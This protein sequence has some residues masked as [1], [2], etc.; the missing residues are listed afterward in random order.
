MTIP[1]AVE[2]Q[3]DFSAGELDPDAE[4][5]D[6][7]DI[8]KAGLKKALNTRPLDVKGITRRQGRRIRYYETGLNER[9]S[10]VS[11]IEFDVTLK[12]NRF[13][14]RDLTGA[15]VSDLAA[16]WT[17][18]MLPELDWELNEKE[19]YVTHRSMPTQVITYDSDAGTWSIADFSF[20]IGLSGETRIPFYR[21]ADFGVTMTPS[22]L[23]GS[24][25][26][27][28]SA[29]VLESQH[30]G[31]LFRYAERQIQIDSITDSQNAAATVIEELPRTQRLTV[32]DIEGYSVGE[33]VEGDT[34]NTVGEIVAVA[35]T[36]VDVVI[37]K[38]LGGFKTSDTLIGPNARSTVSNVADITPGASVQWD[39][40][41]ISEFRG[42]PGAV[43]K[44]RKRLVLCDF[45]QFPEAVLWS[46]IDAPT[47]FKTTGTADGSIF[48]YVPDTGRVYAVVGGADQFVFT[49]R[50][51]YYI[52]ISGSTPLAPG[53]VEFRRIASEGA[54]R[55]RPVAVSD[56]AVFVS[57]KKTRIMAVSATGQ[58]TRPYIVQPISR[59]HGHL[60]KDPIAI[61]AAS[62]AG[63]VPGEALYCVNADG[64][65]IVAR[66]DEGDEWV[67][68]FPWDGA[69]RITDVR[70]G[71]DQ[72]LM[73]V[74][75]DLGMTI[76]AV[77][78]PD[79]D[80]V[81]DSPK[82]A[83]EGF[84][85][86]LIDQNASGMTLVPEN[87][88][89]QAFFVPK[90]CNQCTTPACVQVC[91]VGAT[92][93][94]ADGVVL[95]D[96]TWCIGCGYCIMGCPYG[97]RFF[98]PVEHVADKCTFCYHRII[99]GDNSACAQA[100]PFNAR[101]IGNLKDPNDPVAKAVMT[102]RVGVLRDEYGT[103]PNVYYIGLNKEVR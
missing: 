73:T 13:V 76:E 36:T 64:T 39:E 88:I 55:V 90:L 66:Y 44:D 46:A 75:Y 18:G 22:A 24:I 92:Y 17:L 48:E 83:R 4:R 80:V 16:P 50:R 41:F 33:V 32:P 27:T 68:W 19:I 25:T 14:A 95:V 9:V 60:V 6:D 51:V 97:V 54:A 56:G 91:P 94:T 101:Q 63:G 99:K 78:E 26:I 84:T 15:V 82:G 2:P 5:R 57:S 61:A 69:A 79:G 28:F 53:S 87:E 42:Y 49:D 72:I 98:H 100:C 23:T 31:L 67:G 30:V 21:F 38:N 93:Q 58:Q 12:A 103:K 77:E 65:M 7:V 52:P 47:D 70:G 86:K 62:G 85:S 71:N 102:Q 11:E 34:T 81:M 43:S 1:K 74:A 3:R 59:F 20:L 10:P 8:H 29:P 45:E 96:R 35:A 40:Q 37:T 89:A